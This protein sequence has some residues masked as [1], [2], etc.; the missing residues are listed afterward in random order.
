MNSNY[1][2]IF[3]QPITPRHNI[4]HHLISN[5]NCLNMMLLLYY[6]SNSSRPTFRVH[7]KNVSKNYGKLIFK[8]EG[9]CNMFAFHHGYCQD[10]SFVAVMNIDPFFVRVSFICTII[11]PY[12]K[13]SIFSLYFLHL[14]VNQCRKG[15]I[16]LLLQY[17]TFERGFM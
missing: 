10:S 11:M 8:L 13:I 7:T 15:A 3:L 17:E 1:T 14:H 2:L 9:N 6:T 16:A 4:S 12:N 5:T